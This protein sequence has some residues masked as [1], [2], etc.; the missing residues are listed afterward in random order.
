ML[1]SV[2]YQLLSKCGE[3]LITYLVGLCLTS[4][5]LT[6]RFVR[7][8][9]S[10][11]RNSTA[12]NL[13]IHDTPETAWQEHHAHDVICEFLEANSFNTTRHAYG[14]ATALESRTVSGDKGRTINFNAE[15]DALPGIGHGCG[16]NLIATASIVGY[17]TL[18]HLIKRYSI[19]ATL[20][21]LGT[22][23]EELGGGKVVLL[24]NG[25]FRGVDVSLMAHPCP[26]SNNGSVEY[27]GGCAGLLT[28]S[29]IGIFA[30]YSGK[31]AHAGAE[32]WEGVNALDALVSAY[33]NVSMLRQQ[34][35]P[36]CRI[37]G[38]V[39]EAPKAANIIP[40]STKTFYSIR[41]PKMAAADE[42]AK[43]VEACLSA[44]ALA[45]G[46]GYSIKREA[47]YQDLLPNL[48]LCEAYKSH[49]KAAG[50]DVQVLAT[51]VVRASTDQGNV[52]H[53]MP[54]LHPMFGIPCDAGIK[55][56]SKEFAE[57]AGTEQ[58]FEMAVIVGKALAMTGW[59]LLT[60]EGMFEKAKA[61]FERN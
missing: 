38:A 61:D 56:H 42:L 59:D 12:N 30:T 41:A 18:S 46:C 7:L 58:A 39:I 47:A 4:P 19:D 54:A 28:N 15:Y 36:D 43:K 1:V 10:I 9:L 55:I 22:P 40:E 26:I 31:S 57:V 60:Q 37:H 53:V 25:A 2:S 21:L 5:S 6:E 8:L 48:P 27:P 29:H 49:M 3:T 33:N 35:R 23:A 13:Q 20:Q 17:V 51:E 32:P 45:T 34:M 11:E 44:G 24:E 52:S 14:L 50:K 16:H